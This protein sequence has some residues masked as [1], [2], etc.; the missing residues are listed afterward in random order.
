MSDLNSLAA[1]SD[2]DLMAHL[3]A[4]GNQISWHNA[5]EGSDYFREYPKLVEAKL[6]YYTALAEADERKLGYSSQGKGL[7]L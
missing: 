5:A 7:L 2:Q 4:L 1:M 6:K 3:D